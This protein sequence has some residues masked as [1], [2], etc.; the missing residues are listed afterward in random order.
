MSIY[1]GRQ[2]RRETYLFLSSDPEMRLVNTSPAPCSV[3]RQMQNTTPLFSFIFSYYVKLIHATRSMLHECTI[4]SGKC[5]LNSGRFHHH[6]TKDSHWSLKFVTAKSDVGAGRLLLLIHRYR[7]N[8][9]PRRRIRGSHR[10][11]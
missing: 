1:S 5:M 3:L 11:T 2:M 8:Q 9:D 4:S 10:N 7:Y 6:T